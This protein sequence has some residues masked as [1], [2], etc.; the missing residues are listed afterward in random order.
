MEQL[1]DVYISSRLEATGL[2]EDEAWDLIGEQP[3]GACHM[4]YFTGTNEVA[5]EFVPY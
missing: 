5:S 4:V 1:Y 2:T 3:I